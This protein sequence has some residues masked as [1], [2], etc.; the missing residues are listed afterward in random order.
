MDKSYPNKRDCKHGRLRGK[1]ADCEVEE[2]EAAFAEKGLLV[3]E[4]A[5]EG[6]YILDTQKVLDNLCVI[7]YITT[8]KTNSQHTE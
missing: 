4:L 8:M 7:V 5:K 6:I 1:C 2:L 3:L